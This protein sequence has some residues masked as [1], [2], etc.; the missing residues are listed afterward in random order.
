[1]SKK[2]MTFTEV[3]TALKKKGFVQPNQNNPELV[4]QPINQNSS[5]TRL[6][7]PI[8]PIITQ[9][10]KQ[11]ISFQLK[12]PISFFEDMVECHKGQSDYEAEL[13]KYRANISSL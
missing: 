1:M 6:K 10:V 13:R 8:K 9:E 12:I 2:L 5:R 3:S 11:Q 7:P 4:F